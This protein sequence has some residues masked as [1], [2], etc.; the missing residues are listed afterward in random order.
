VTARQT[1]RPR[2]ALLTGIC[3]RQV[4]VWTFLFGPGATACGLPPIRFASEPATFHR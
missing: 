4:E 2:S 1:S 3:Q